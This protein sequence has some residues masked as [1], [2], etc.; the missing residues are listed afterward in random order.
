M[1]VCPANPR[2]SGG[3]QRELARTSPGGP[4][5]GRAQGLI[6]GAP[7]GREVQSTRQ[8]PGGRPFRAAPPPGNAS[9]P[10]KAEGVQPAAR[11]P[12]RCFLRLCTGLGGRILATMG[13][14][15]KDLLM[16]GADRPL[17]A[18]DETRYKTSF[19]W[20]W[21]VCQDVRQRWITEAGSSLV[22]WGETVSPGG[23]HQRF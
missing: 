11:H 9:P 17:W 4:A 18:R 15:L 12:G 14:F 16:P 19:V 7:W 1:P 13:D 5:W 21:A 20:G 2:P 3:H 23:P 10:V 22:L 8:K 6:L